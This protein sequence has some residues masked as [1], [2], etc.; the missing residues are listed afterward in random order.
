MNIRRSLHDLSQPLTA[1]IGLIYL[2]SLQ[3]EE[4]SKFNQIL[5][6]LNV[7][8]GQIKTITKHIQNISRAA[9]LYKNK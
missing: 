9:T 6:T 2:M 1:A 4:D 8:L 5:L 3:L 7:Q